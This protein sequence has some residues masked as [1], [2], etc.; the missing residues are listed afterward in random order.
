MIVST[1]EIVGGGNLQLPKTIFSVK[2]RVCE[3]GKG[4]KGPILN[5]QKILIPIR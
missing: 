5:G 2:V 3:C 1:P 4:G